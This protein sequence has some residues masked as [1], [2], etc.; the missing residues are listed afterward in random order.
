M[1]SNICFIFILF[2]IYSFI[3]WS[4]EVICKLIE[5]HKFINRG[6]LIGPY[7][8]IY[9]FGCLLITML[10]YRYK[11]DFFSLFV[12][13]MLVCSILEYFT[14]FI[15]EKLFKTR[16]WDYSTKKFNLNGRICLDTM[17][18]FGMIGCIVMYVINPF[19]TKILSI[20]PPNI[21]NIIAIILFAA[22]IIDNI[23]SFKVI[24]GIRTTITN[25]EKDATEEITKKVKEIIF[26][27]GFLYRRILNAFPNLKNKKERLLELKAKINDDLNKFTS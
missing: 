26:R 9:G 10:L 23:L 2:I 8:P 25:T 20:I 19:F 1:F 11:D 7:C 3:G 12:M 5:K 16:W 14:S 13:S 21:L 15:M 27:K 22:F 24:L 17:V 18:P 6:F 4:M